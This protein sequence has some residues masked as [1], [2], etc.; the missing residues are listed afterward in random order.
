[1]IMVIPTKLKNLNIFHEKIVW[2]YRH[3]VIRDCLII[4]PREGNLSCTKVL[5]VFSVIVYYGFFVSLHLFCYIFLSSSASFHEFN[6]CQEKP[7]EYW[8]G[9]RRLSFF[10]MCW[11]GL[12]L[13]LCST[14]FNGNYNFSCL[15]EVS[16]LKSVYL[17][18]S[19][20]LMFYL[21]NF[22]LSNH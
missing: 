22:F 2:D 16:Y 20:L 19:L 13:Y 11:E 10:Q 12:T 15:V 9:K 18:F 21:R 3:V 7:K 6:A 4:S 1:M 8:V 17:V 14:W 5:S